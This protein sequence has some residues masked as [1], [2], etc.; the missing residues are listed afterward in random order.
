MIRPFGKRALSCLLVAGLCCVEAAAPMFAAH[1]DEATDG[2]QRTTLSEFERFAAFARLDM[3]H[4]LVA[5]DQP[6][7]AVRELEAYFA[8]VPEDMDSRLLHI[9]LLYQLARCAEAAT[10]ARALLALKPEQ[11]EAQ[12]YLGLSLL[13]LGDAEGAAAAFESA[14]S[15]PDLTAEQR[16]T[17]L[18]SAIDAAR[19]TGDAA[20]IR[21]VLARL[22]AEYPDDTDVLR[23]HIDLTLAHEQKAEALEAARRLGQVAPTPA[24]LEILANV[25]VLNGAPAEA[26]DIYAGLATNASGDDAARLLIASANAWEAA[27]QPDAAAQAFERAARTFSP[28]AEVDES[29]SPGGPNG[30]GQPGNR[31]EALQ[32]AAFAWQQAGN[33]DAAIVNITNALDLT[34][35]PDLQLAA[36]RLFR[37][38]GRDAEAAERFRAA[39]SP[40]APDDVIQV[41]IPALVDVLSA[42]GRDDEAQAVLS[43]AYQRGVAVQ[44]ALAAQVLERAGDAEG[45]LR[46]LHLSPPAVDG[47]ERARQL[48]QAGHLLARMG[49]QAEAGER[50]LEA[51]QTDPGTASAYLYMAATAFDGAGEQAR[52]MKCYEVYLQRGA[53]PGRVTE[54]WLA[55][56]NLRAAAGDTHGAALAFERVLDGPGLSSSS[57]RRVA[58][59]SSLM[60]VQAANGNHEAVCLAGE[61]LLAVPDLPR[62]TAAATHVRVA[63]AL[64]SLGRAEEALTHL[65]RRVD[66]GG[67]SPDTLRAIAFLEYDLGRYADA[68]RDFSRALELGDTPGVRLGLARSLARQ[69]KSGLAVHHYLLAGERLD[70]L[71]PDGAT[72][73]ER[74]AYWSELGMLYDTEGQHSQAATAYSRA[75]E[76][77]DDPVLAY[78]LGRALRLA[79]QP[80][81]AATR[82]AALDPDEPD[83][84]LARAGL[85]PQVWSE[86]AALAGQRED[87][88]E[89]ARL[90]ERALEHVPGTPDD[91]AVRGLKADLLARLGRARALQS[92][93]RNA[94]EVLAYT[95]AARLSGSPTVRSALGYA[96]FDAG[97]YSGAARTFDEAVE[98]GADQPNLIEDTAY[99]WYRAGENG[100]AVQRFRAAVDAL[101]ANPEEDADARAEQERRSYAL[102]Q[103]VTK[104]EREL[105]VALFMSYQGGDVLRGK[106]A[107]GSDVVRANSGMEASWVPP[108]IGL[109]DDR[110]FQ[111]VGR[112]TWSPPRET[113]KLEQRTAQGA[114]GVRYR[115]LRD[116]NLHFGVERLVAIGNDAEDNWL[117]RALWSISDGADVRH[118]DTLYNYSLLYTEGG[119]YTDSPSRSSIYVEGRQ[120]VTINYNETVLVRPHMFAAVRKW[121]PDRDDASFYEFGPGVS[122]RFL[123]N[124]TRYSTPRSSFDIMLQY[125]VGRFYNQDGKDSRSEEFL[126]T[127][128]L[129]Y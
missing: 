82:L 112:V 40:E 122:L 45:A 50:F 94:A 18:F 62:Q 28:P 101:A 108:G 124:E 35:T 110:L 98:G 78:R 71:T 70:D 53:E 16:R 102:R 107:T 65:E 64:A 61:Q 120:G 89:E 113:L 46:L 96:L 126:L 85:V 36:G 23:T 118:G 15:A 57:P 123:F 81:E 59:L 56:G 44:P 55:L 4:R 115:P 7:Q 87:R 30:P 32:A 2:G 14:A 39:A 91:A 66:I 95:E 41:A 6:E 60:E 99:A 37:Q 8:I 33:V 73:D 52:A 1:A 17:A 125:G 93:R 111:V 103:E 121:I 75:I 109:V 114:V 119:H 105:S 129:S 77:A 63:E 3:A 67:D 117:L 47:A 84:P 97:D 83:G 9:R 54:A 19:K 11:N 25:L 34:D 31:R 128:T 80:D 38:I 26:A 92:P 22:L 49:R 86:R 48:E 43:E 88:D 90:L 29:G 72:A 69:G 21:A 10:Q 104:I 76:E 106:G 100:M 20:G 13:E 116:W 27:G 79:G 24:H 68:V 51:A 58:V 74:R 42:L 5:Q 127:T 12:L